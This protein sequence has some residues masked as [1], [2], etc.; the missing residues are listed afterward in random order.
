MRRYQSPKLS[1]AASRRTGRHGPVP[2]GDRSRRDVKLLSTEAKIRDRWR[3]IREAKNC[4]W[5]EL[6]APAI[7]TDRPAPSGGTRRIRGSPFRAKTLTGE[8]HLGR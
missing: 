5:S 2:P 1:H 8:L 7:S 4:G 6:Q 3:R